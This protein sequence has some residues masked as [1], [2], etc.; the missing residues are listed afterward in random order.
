MALKKR[1]IG[2]LIEEFNELSSYKRNNDLFNSLESLLKEEI[3]SNPKTHYAHKILDYSHDGKRY[4]FFFDG[5]SQLESFYYQSKQKSLLHIKEEL[6]LDNQLNLVE[7]ISDYFPISKIKTDL[8]A[9]N[10]SLY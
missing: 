2:Y 4:L 3:F 10:Y 6:P 1:Q 7:E 8:K 9:A 5:K